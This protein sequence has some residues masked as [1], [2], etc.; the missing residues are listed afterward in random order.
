[1]SRILHRTLVADPL[2]ATR[3]EGI[4]L[5]TADG[6]TIIDASGGA[7]VACL[8]HGNRRVAE[9][10]G[11]QAATMAYAHTGT[12][13]NQPAEE[14]ADIIVGRRTRRPDAGLVLLLRLRR[15]RGGDQ[16]GA[17]VFPRDRPAPAHPHH[18][19]PAVLSRHHTWRAG[20]RRQH[21]APRAITSRS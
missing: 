6:R 8:G 10:I 18:R 13:S 11:R 20:R 12:F 2:F 15:Q 4:Y 1:M 7:A 17:A 14:L 19:A 16:A 9:A 3:G 5:H 21:D